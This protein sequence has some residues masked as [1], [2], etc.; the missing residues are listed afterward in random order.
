MRSSEGI[1][2]RMRSKKALA[3]ISVALI[4]QIVAII[5][6]LILPRLIISTFG[7]DVNGLINSITQFL[8]YIILL[9]AGV[10]ELFVQLYIN[11]W[12]VVISIP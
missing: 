11:R 7:S 8:G 10:G 1:A 9:E 3:N 6:G 5:C 12:Q 4:L 2:V